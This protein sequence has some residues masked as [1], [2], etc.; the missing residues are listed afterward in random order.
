MIIFA[1]AILSALL[2]VLSAVCSMS[3]QEWRTSNGALV[4]ASCALT[5]RSASVRVTRDSCGFML[6]LKKPK[7]NT[8][9]GASAWL[10]DLAKAV[11][12]QWTPAA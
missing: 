12:L 11:H 2:R 9:S 6:L 8:P 5:R 1:I 10:V 7:Q 3:T 4:R